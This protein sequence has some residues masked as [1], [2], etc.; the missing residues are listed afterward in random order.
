MIKGIVQRLN[1]WGL[2][3][4]GARDLVSVHHCSQY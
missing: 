4:F 1:E 2:W 3:R